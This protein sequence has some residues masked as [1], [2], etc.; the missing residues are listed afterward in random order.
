MWMKIPRNFISILLCRTVYIGG[1]GVSNC[2]V[3]CRFRLRK[4]SSMR[5]MERPIMVTN[6]RLQHILGVAR[7]C[8]EYSD[9]LFGWD[10]EKCS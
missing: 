8:Y 1:V 4:G 3:T 9:S 5:H 6:D 2:V 7:A 10:V